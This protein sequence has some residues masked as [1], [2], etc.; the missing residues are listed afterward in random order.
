MTRVK[1]YSTQSG[2]SFD[3]VEFCIPLWYCGLFIGSNDVQAE[4]K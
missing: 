4:D 3:T 1:A 2:C